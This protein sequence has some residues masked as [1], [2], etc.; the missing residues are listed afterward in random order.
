MKTIC[1]FTLRIIIVLTILFGTV[2]SVAA[3]TPT[4]TV[5]SS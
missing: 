5:T 1:H 2:T 3:Q 4:V